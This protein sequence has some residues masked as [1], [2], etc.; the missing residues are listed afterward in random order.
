MSEQ[1]LAARRPRWSKYDAAH[2]A[3]IRMILD[4]EDKGSWVAYC[5]DCDWKGDD[6]MPPE[7]AGYAAAQH[8][9]EA[10]TP[11][12][13]AAR[14]SQSVGPSEDYKAL[15]RGEIS[16]AEYVRR[17]KANVDARVAPTRPRYDTT[18]AYWTGASA[19]LLL[20]I[21]LGWL[22]TFSVMR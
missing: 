14:G 20:G 3:R 19:G 12:R 15:L 21:V 4:G 6:P 11:D 22:V 16:S 17:M 5:L 18:V 2:G 8:E 10:H 9:S 13:V 1:P 7:A